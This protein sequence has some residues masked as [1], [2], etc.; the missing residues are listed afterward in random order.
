MV[1]N[2]I[3]NVYVKVPENSLSVKSILSAVATKLSS[4]PEDLVILDVKFLEVTDDKGTVTALV[5]SMLVLLY[6]MLQ[7]LTIGRPR[8][9]SCMLHVNVNMRM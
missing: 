5:A 8:V 3:N 7:T 1:D 6:L 2:T 9:G 4:T